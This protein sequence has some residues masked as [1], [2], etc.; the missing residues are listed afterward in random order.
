M[1]VRSFAI[2]GWIGK[3]D[4]SPC[5]ILVAYRVGLADPVAVCRAS[6][7]GYGASCGEIWHLWT[8]PGVL[9][10]VLLLC[11][12]M[13]RDGLGYRARRWSDGDSLVS[14]CV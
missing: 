5:C 9:S 2:W 1:E 13:L 7:V 8:G 6:M 10:G 4:Y 11:G 12:E 3:G 14:A